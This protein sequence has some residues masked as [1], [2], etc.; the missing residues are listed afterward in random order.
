MAS[1]LD[2]YLYQ[3][4]LTMAFY[5]KALFYAS[6]MALAGTAGCSSQ[7]HFEA[8]P[9]FKVS[10][11]TVQVIAAGRESGGAT[12]ELSFH[13]TAEDPEMVQLD[14]LYFRGRV[15]TPELTQTQTGMLVT[16]RYPLVALEKSDLIMH[17]DSTKEVG[18]QPPAPL[19]VQ[20]AFPF[21]LEANQAVLSYR[22]G[23]DAALR[24]F[25]IENVA[26]KP[27]RAMPGRP[28]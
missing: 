8:A 12:S 27:V 23:S 7:K 3:S 26:D 13:F 5:M 9:P 11:P 2:C 20:N 10:N 19:P 15:L 17:A 22:V 21:E 18:N 14:S 28:H 25:H 16:A 24:Y 4:N 1:I 6:L